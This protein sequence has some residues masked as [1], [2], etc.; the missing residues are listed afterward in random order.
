[1]LLF[2]VVLMENCTVRATEAVSQAEGWAGLRI[3]KL[4]GDNAFQPLFQS[5][6]VREMERFIKQE[7]FSFNI[8]CGP[9]SGLSWGGRQ[10]GGAQTWLRW[11]DFS[12]KP[13]VCQ[14]FGGGLWGEG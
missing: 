3:V 7:P 9:C 1:M 14:Q 13:S 8:H 10:R 12:T 2:L 5:N 11:W 6:K 4:A